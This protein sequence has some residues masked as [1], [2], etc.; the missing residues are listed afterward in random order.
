M[1][2]MSEAGCVGLFFGIDSGSE[3][4][5]E[6]IN[7]RL[8]LQEA[9]ARVK[10]ANRLKIATTVSL[11]TGFHEETRE[12]LRATLNFYGESILQRTTHLRRHFFRPLLPRLGARPG[13]SQHDS[14]PSGH[15]Y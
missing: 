14:C 10:S 3:R 6:I 1:L 13:R 2:R 4:I 12:D 7:K 8:D 15:L 11:I 9:A 5:Q